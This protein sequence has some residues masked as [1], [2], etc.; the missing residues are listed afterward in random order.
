MQV[1]DE[2]EDG[3]GVI[4]EKTLKR[5]VRLLVYI[6][7]LILPNLANGLDADLVKGEY[8]QIAK[9]LVKEA[10]EELLGGEPWIHCDEIKRLISRRAP[11]ILDPV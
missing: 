9:S 5:L 7:V 10:V 3:D 11:F 1:F 6:S 4:K 2:D 8:H